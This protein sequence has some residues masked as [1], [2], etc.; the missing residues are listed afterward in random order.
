MILQTDNST[1]VI[2]NN[3]PYFVLAASIFYQYDAHVKLYYKI[4]GQNSTEMKQYN[5]SNTNKVEINEI[6]N[7]VSFQ[8]N[9]DH[10]FYNIV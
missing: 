3:K 9:F 1:E 8:S 2:R 5:F 6:I 10:Q 7:I 4:D